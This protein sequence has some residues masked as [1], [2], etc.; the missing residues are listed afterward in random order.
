VAAGPLVAQHE[1]YRKLTFVTSGPIFYVAPVTLPQPTSPVIS[2][3]T[4]CAVP[5]PTPTTAATLSI[6][7][8]AL[9]ASSVFGDTFRATEL[10]PVLAHAVQPGKDPT[11]NDLPFLLA[12]HRCHLDHRTTNRRSA[13]DRLLIWIEGNAGSIEFG[14]GICDV[15]NAAPQSVDGP[16]HQDIE[17][18]PYRVLEHLVE[19]GALIPTF[20]S[21]DS[22]ILVGLDDQPATVFGHLLQHEPLI[23]SALVVTAHAQVDRRANAIGL[24]YSAQPSL[25]NYNAMIAPIPK[26]SNYPHRMGGNV[27]AV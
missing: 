19:C 6:P 16:H 4:R 14:E 15:K 24:H 5:L 17:P 10:L 7:L 11:A 27:L 3:F 12:K 21:A 8:P 23:L 26:L 2:G 18:S 13:V 20:G 9:M 22:L 25:W 1:Y